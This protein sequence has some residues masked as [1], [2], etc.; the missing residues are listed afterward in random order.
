MQCATARL[1]G[2]MLSSLLI[3]PNDV[4][5]GIAKAGGYFRSVSADRLDDL[6]A[7]FLNEVERGLNVIHHDIE[8]QTG[9]IQSWPVKYPCAADLT[10]AIVEG[11]GAVAPRA[12]IPVKDLLV[13]FG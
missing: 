7:V 3:E 2:R 8:K 10:Y 11:D 9:L 4:S 12:N 5:A 6:T 1:L 13:K